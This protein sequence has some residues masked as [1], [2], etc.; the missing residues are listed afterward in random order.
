MRVVQVV[1]RFKDGLRCYNINVSLWNVQV[2]C[3]CILVLMLVWLCVCNASVK[4]IEKQ[5]YTN[6][7]VFLI[8]ESHILSHI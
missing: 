2:Q 8:V 1:A 6:A 3:V 5:R 7:L 4:C